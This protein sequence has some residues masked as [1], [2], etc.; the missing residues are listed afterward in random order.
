MITVVGSLVMDLAIQVPEFPQPDGATHGG[1]FQ[2]ACGGKGANQ[3]V[4]IARMGVPVGL[5]GIAGLD[6]F[7]DA[8]CANLAAAGVD[9]SRVARRDAGASGV[10]IVLRD[11]A[12]RREIVVANGIN[13]ALSPADVERGAGMLRDS[14]MLVAQLETSA[15]SV[16][17]AL[18]LARQLH[19]PVLLNPAPAFRCRPEWLD[20]C[21]F[22]IVNEHEAT[23][24]SG[25]PVRDAE[26]AAAAA[27]VLKSLGAVNVLVT[28]G[29]AGVWVDAAEWQGRLPGH[30]VEEV[31]PIGAGDTFVGAFAAR[32]CA[33]AGAG[34]HEAA[35]FANA[36][37]A[38]SVTR[39]GAQPGIP[40][41]DEVEVF[42]AGEAGRAA[43]RSP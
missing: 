14:R 6:A 8:M 20:G 31:D 22:V 24:L 30:A 16:A 2:M 39:R 11:S 36:A 34:V 28:L 5:I 38:I 37:A 18:R 26:S 33:G 10:F 7:G 21:E 32:L 41:R 25:S 29:A 23:H 9:I 27:Q 42:L 1:D 40:R 35:R 15:E 17:T 12:G 3:A 4:A 19:V 13:A 43:R